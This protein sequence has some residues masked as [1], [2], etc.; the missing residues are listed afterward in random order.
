MRKTLQ[1]VSTSLWQRRQETDVPLSVSAVWTVRL[2]SHNLK[3]GRRS[4]C[5]RE[6]PMTIIILGISGAK[7][8]A[9]RKKIQNVTRLAPV[10]ILNR[11][12]GTSLTWLNTFSQNHTRYNQL[13]LYMIC[14]S[15]GKYA[16]VPPI[17][18]QMQQRR[19]PGSHVN[20]GLPRCLGLWCAF[21]GNY[22]YATRGCSH[23]ANSAV[24]HNRF[25]A[26]AILRVCIY[27][28]IC[29]YIYNAGYPG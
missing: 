8:L 25:Y 24:P 14:V 1:L 13:L 4:V 5:C 3:P 12:H 15:W 20:W 28:S 7:I 11:L 18:A 16:D 10:P 23:K 17:E 29:I 26:C 9:T 2:G 27:I 6:I 19:R 21:I 22:I